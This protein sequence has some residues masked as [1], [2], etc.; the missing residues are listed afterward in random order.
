[1]KNELILVCALSSAVVALASDAAKISETGATALSEGSVAVSEGV[2]LMTVG[3][4]GLAAG[5]VRAGLEVPLWMLE[6]TAEVT[7]ALGEGSA[8]AL[9]Q[10][11]QGRAPLGKPSRTKE[12]EKAVLPAPDPRPAEFIEA[13]RKQQEVRS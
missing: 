7:E 12:T 8:E 4:S 13:R 10:H 5:G 9:Q 6:R 2:A 11:R 3:A 1:M